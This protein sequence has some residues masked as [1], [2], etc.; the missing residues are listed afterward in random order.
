MSLV[1]EARSRAVFFA[2]FLAG[3][4][5][6]FATGANAANNWP[7]FGNDSGNT[8]S[9]QSGI[10]K[11]NI[12]KLHKAWST[13][14]G[15]DVSARA[16][17][18]D[19]VVYFPDWGGNLWALDAGTGAVIWSH[20]LSDYGLAANTHSRT[21]PAVVGGKLY[22]GT[23]EGAYVLGIDAASG[24]LL[25]KTQVESADPAAMVTTSPAVANGIV[26]TGVA[27]NQEALAAFGFPCCSARGSAVALDA[28]TGAI[29]W[30]TYTVPAGY[31]GG[32]VWGSS[33]VVD[34]ARHTVFVS[35]G[36]NYSHPT[37]LMYLSCIAA[38]HAE[39][40][41]L[42]PDDHVDS[43]LALDIS[44]GSVK[45]ATRLVDWAQPGIADGSDDWNV[46][47]FIPPFT[48]CPTNAG[49][50]YDFGSA[51]NEITYQSHGGHK[52]IIG[53]GQKSGIYYALD[54]DTGMEL[55][56][57]QVGPG[58]SLGGIEWGSASDGTRIYVAISNYYGI[59]YSAGLAGS[60]AALDPATGAILW[61][62]SDPNGSIDLGPV[63][64]SKD[65]VYA[66]SM[67]GA[68]DAQTMFALDASNGSILWSYPA[69]SSVIA[70]ATIADNMVFWGSGYA[71]L[72]I[73]GFTGG[74]TFYGFSK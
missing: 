3:G 19:G 57:T 27:S 21:T 25:W 73:A 44:T 24:A 37:D 14:V 67:A 2:I 40:E 15:G 42:A 10:T 68:P 50:D 34:L 35:T 23:Q 71:H 61:Q 36:N 18:V 38:G 5:G 59:P 7:A 63:A 66:A 65:I 43:V 6:A 72:G 9:A 16:A 47:C 13:T 30:K 74:N 29:V 8:A 56:R 26:Y 52:T 58:S 31:T 55:W 46:A 49:P 70:G 39:A 11:G 62:T 60:W 45:W 32:S 17:M 64:V 53:A 4:F 48:N 54:P 12:R 28:A 20:Q 33:P 22:L 41:C 69:G 1:R 51:P